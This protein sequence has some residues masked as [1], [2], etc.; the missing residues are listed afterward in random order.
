M[1]FPQANE[2]IAQVSFSLIRW[3][4]FPDSPE[5]FGLTLTMS[6]VACL[7]GRE[8]APQRALRLKGHAGRTD[9]SHGGDDGTIDE[10]RMGRGAV[11]VV[12]RG[13]VRGA[14]E[15]YLAHPAII[16]Q[17]TGTCRTSFAARAASAGL[18][19]QTTRRGDTR[20]GWWRR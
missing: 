20:I 18:E 17:F 9:A 3:K 10:I 1:N 2:E 19:R 11:A 14:R 15:R 6:P 16:Q 5:E 4:G 12:H 13:G 8:P 7:M